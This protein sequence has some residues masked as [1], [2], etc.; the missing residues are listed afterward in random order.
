[1]N[2]WPNR[3]YGISF[4]VCLFLATGFSVATAR[5]SEPTCSS[6]FSLGFTNTLRNDENVLAVHITDYLPKEGYIKASTANNH[7]FGAT[8]HFALG[9]PVKDHT[10]GNWSGRPYAVLLPL[11]SMKNQVLNVMAQ[12][13]FVLGDVKLPQNAV[14]LVP[15]N[16]PMD[17]HA[18]Y[19]VERYDSKIGIK[20]AIKDYIAKSDTIPFESKGGWSFNNVIIKDQTLRNDRLQ[21]FF[22]ELYA[23]NPRLT[24]ELHESTPWGAVDI[25]IL[26]T[27]G[28]WKKNGVANSV[29]TFKTYLNVLKVN[30]ALFAIKDQIK[31][32]KL[33]PHSER[34]FDAS[35][36]V[37]K[38]NMNLLEADLNLRTSYGKSVLQTDMRNQQALWSEI[39]RSLKDPVK[40][41]D[42]LLQNK[43]SFS[44]AEQ[45]A[46]I[47]TNYLFGVM[48]NYP[49]QSFKDLVGKM[50]P[51]P[52]ADTRAEIAHYLEQKIASDVV[53]NKMASENA[54]AEI[55]SLRK[56]AKYDFYSLYREV[57]TNTIEYPKGSITK[58]IQD[59]F[60]A[61]DREG[62]FTEKELRS[63]YTGNM[64]KTALVDQIYQP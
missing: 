3:L 56:N 21:T 28:L 34:S 9:E 18:P 58:N 22:K 36:A 2:L 30:D 10:D 27:V 19:R 16:T 51:R 1:M 15:E 24:S 5:A 64:D 42:I 17:S 52:S 33:P 38:E 61:L 60:K 48:K 46:S 11:A 47:P 32:M 63:W 62:M 4:T 41:K 53:G 54:I 12:D 50:N 57:V 7:R 39:K 13:T 43:N 25:T 29:D 37:L 40:L 44:S 14:V 59:F 26:E 8:L 55:K 45:A 20:Q 6:I 35:M 31:E 49:Y 23:E